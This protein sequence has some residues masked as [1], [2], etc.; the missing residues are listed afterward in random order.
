MDKVQQM[1]LMK[2]VFMDMAD[3]FLIHKI[4]IMEFES[5]YVSIV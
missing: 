5:K 1:H 3:H 2:A 4:G